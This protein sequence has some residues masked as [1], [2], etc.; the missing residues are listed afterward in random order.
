MA[1]TSKQEGKLRMYLSL[2]I[3]L[4]MNDVIVAKLPNSSEFLTKLDQAIVDIQSYSEQRQAGTN[5]VTNDKN[6][7]RNAL[8]VTTVD[9]SNKIQAYAKYVDNTALLSKTKI[10]NSIFK[11][12]SDLEAAELATVLYKSINEN[13]QFLS[14][15][16]LNAESQKEFLADITDFKEAIPKV[17]QAQIEQKGSTT[18]LTVSFDKADAAVENIDMLVEIVRLSEPDFYNDYQ[19]S[20]VVSDSSG[21]LAVKGLVTDSES[22]SPIEDATVSFYLGE[23]GDKPLLKKQTA[24]KGGYSIKSLDEGIYSVVVQK[25]GYQT[26]TIKITVSSEKCCV[27]KIKLVKI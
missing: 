22:G 1:M 12:A 4:K 24:E 2:R 10:T 19:L 16:N 23:V 9:A 27:V 26:L 11:A 6:K 21:S 3:F 15:Y 14:G 18:H 5:D 8:G 20:R 7:L 13:L 25:V 17:K